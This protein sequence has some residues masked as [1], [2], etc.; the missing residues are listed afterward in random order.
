MAIKIFD[1]ELKE[2]LRDFY[3]HIKY[4]LTGFA[5][6]ESIEHHEICANYINSIKTNSY[7]SNL[8]QSSKTISISS[9]VNTEIHEYTT[10]VKQDGG[11][12]LNS[13][14][15]KMVPPLKRAVQIGHFLYFVGGETDSN[16]YRVDIDAGTYRPEVYISLNQEY[17]SS[18]YCIENDKNGH[19]VITGL[20]TKVAV[21][22]IDNP[23]NI[24]YISISDTQDRWIGLTV[25]TLNDFAI[26]SGYGE[27][28]Q[29]VIFHN[30]NI[31][32]T[33]DSV[34]VM[35]INYIDD[36]LYFSYQSGYSFYLYKFDKQRIGEQGYEP[37]FIQNLDTD[38]FNGH[39]IIGK[40]NSDFPVSELRGK[41]FYA[42]G[43]ADNNTKKYSVLVSDDG[44]AT[45]S[46]YIIP[47]VATNNGYLV[48]MNDGRYSMNLRGLYRIASLEP[49]ETTFTVEQIKYQNKNYW[50]IPVFDENGKMTHLYHEKFTPSTLSTEPGKHETILYSYTNISIPSDGP[51]LIDN[52]IFKDRTINNFFCIANNTDTG[53][54]LHIYPRENPDNKKIFLIVDSRDYL[55]GNVYF[56]EAEYQ[57]NYI[58]FTRTSDIV[59]CISEVPELSIT[60]S[61]PLPSD[62]P[63]NTVT[64][65]TFNGVDTVITTPTVDSS[66]S[67]SSKNPVQNAV[68]QHELATKL[69]TDRFVELEHKALTTDGIKQDI[70]LTPVDV[71]GTISTGAW[72]PTYPLVDGK[73]WKLA[74]SDNPTCYK[75]YDVSTYDTVHLKATDRLGYILTESLPSDFNTRITSSGSG[76]IYEYPEPQGT[77]AGTHSEQ[78]NMQERNPSQFYDI[79]ITTNGRSYLIVYEG[80]SFQGA[81]V[82]YPGGYAPIPTSMFV[83]DGEGGSPL[84]PFVTESDLVPMDTKID[85]II[86]KIATPYPYVA[87][88][89][90][91]G[92]SG[93]TV[94]SEIGFSFSQ[95]LTAT[96][97]QNDAGDLTSASFAGESFTEQELEAKAKQKTFSYTN[98]TSDIT[99]EASFTYEDGPIYDNDFGIPDSRGM[100]T[101][102][103]ITAELKL[104]PRY[105][106][107]FG[108]V[109]DNWTPSSSSIRNNLSSVLANGSSSQTITLSTTNTK[110]KFVVAVPNTKHISS[111]ID[112]SANN[113][114]C[115][116][117]YVLQPNTTVVKDAGQN[118][119]DYNVYIMEMGVV[120]PS[121]HQHKITIV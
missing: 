31:V 92:Y 25:N 8:S 103:T 62:N 53:V 64:T 72:Y 34:R 33:V 101:G 43:H 106:Y 37:E 67:P 118:D 108:P 45:S 36:I 1:P 120:Y 95:T 54:T 55:N 15:Q 82:S 78:A 32:K 39:G 81:I 83:N 68:I 115:T 10:F 2:T 49:G 22:D 79:D 84:D 20:S 44:F 51:Y 88:T 107:F 42:C 93:T 40:F 4:V 80:N 23:S 111:A 112:A 110:K 61:T 97:T 100:I 57:Y 91:T 58:Y 69:P 41:I 59:E 35:S 73:Q 119:R 28:K 116:N 77:P 70:M 76:N 102:D 48:L 65:I 11:Y 17:F 21:V 121:S 52:L 96:F 75:I 9:G 90:S 12:Q 98:I 56:F 7:Y 24:S 117:D 109:D 38:K 86:A 26:S 63:K 3:S 18:T 105:R 89:C 71:Y 104:I 50:Y 6:K 46:E 94:T 66:L 85:A 16:I 113:Y 99:I 27:N 5:K 30:G 60:Q 29:I 47:G 74:P 19:F 13:N 14:D 87:P 114:P